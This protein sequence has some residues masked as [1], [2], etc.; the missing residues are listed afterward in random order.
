MNIIKTVSVVIPTRNRLDSLNRTLA[1]IEK[2]TFVPNEVIIVDSSDFAIQKNQ[3]LGNFNNSVL[4]IIHSKP[5]VCE[6]RNIGIKKCTSNYIF[7]C[8]DDIEISE[9]Y[10]ESLVLFLESNPNEVVCSGLIMENKNN[11]W[12]YCEPK[13]S[14]FNLFLAYIFGFSV[15]FEID[16][17]QF[18]ENY[19][20]KKIV[21]FYIKKGNFISK[22]GWPIITNFKE[23][24]FKTP[25]YGL[26]ASIIKAENLK[27]VLFDTAFY[28]NGIGDNYDLTIG[29]NHKINV[30]KSAKAYHYR[31]KTNRIN[32]DKAYFYRV[33]A[34]HYILK[35]HQRFSVQNLIFLFWSLAGNS[36]IFLL[37]GKIKI[38]FYN[39]ELIFRIIFNLPLYKSKN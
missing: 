24:V 31:E 23:D 21:D 16:R 10:L 1:S 30:I 22:S 28:E 20:T 9:N 2:Q 18:Y 6:Q 34:L 29:L 14:I 3:L 17:K 25:I 13:K 7:L 4:Q 36:V 33:A 8:D 38:F 19:F 27:K 12:T 26:G 15:G 39:F 32:N 11:L 37:N 5:S 35:K